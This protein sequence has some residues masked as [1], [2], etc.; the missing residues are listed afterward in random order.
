M[1]TAF[2]STLILALSTSAGFAQ[3]PAQCIPNQTIPTSRPLWIARQGRVCARCAL[4]SSRV[5]AISP[6]TNVMI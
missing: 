5:Q 3:Q 1:K 6:A 2:L 4:R